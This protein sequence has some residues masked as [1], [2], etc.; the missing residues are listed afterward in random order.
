[1]PDVTITLTATEAAAV[2]WAANRKSIT[3]AQ[4][5]RNALT[6]ELENLVR[7]HTERRWAVRRT[8]LA[9]NPPLA[10]T[11]DAAASEPL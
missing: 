7:L 4:W 3:A 1:M 5:L 6:G 11:V 8:T 10:A 2:A 9:A